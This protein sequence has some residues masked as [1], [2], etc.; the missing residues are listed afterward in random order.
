MSCLIPLVDIAIQCIAVAERDVVLLDLGGGN[1]SGSCAQALL[2]LIHVGSLAVTAV[3]AQNLPLGSLS[4]FQLS[5]SSRRPFQALS[6]SMS[7]SMP[8]MH[9]INPQQL[10]EKTD[11]KTLPPDFIPIGH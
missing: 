2:T 11:T 6:N 3:R 10:S 1:H 4:I 9:L 5:A 7:I 8:V